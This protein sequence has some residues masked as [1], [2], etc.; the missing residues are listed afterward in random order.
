VVRGIEYDT[1]QTGFYTILKNWQLKAMQ[2]LWVTPNGINSWMVW[3]NVNNALKGES[4]STASIINFLEDMRKIGVLSGEEKTGKG[5]YHWIY[6]PKLD[7]GGFKKYIV[8]KMIASLMDSFPEETREA[9][10]KI[11]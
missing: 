6:Y 4:I 7:E 3:L 9:I 2:V 8:E 1:S 5:G 10:K 11:E